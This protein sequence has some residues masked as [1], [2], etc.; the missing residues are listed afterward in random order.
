[1]NVEQS[2]LYTTLG[3]EL[4]PHRK[5]T[6]L[7]SSESGN[8]VACVRRVF[9]EY[10]HRDTSN[11]TDQTSVGARVVSSARAGSESIFAYHSGC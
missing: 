2:V 4:P 9:E 10:M 8:L 1:M 6:F 5:S 11:A 7:R 3:H